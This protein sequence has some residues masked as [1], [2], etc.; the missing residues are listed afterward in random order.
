MADLHFVLSCSQSS[1]S[2][3]PHTDRAPRRTLT[4]SYFCSQPSQSLCPH[5]DRAP[6]RILTSSDL[7]PNPDDHCARTRIAPFGG[8]S[9]RPIVPPTLTIPCAHA[10]RAPQGRSVGGVSQT[11]LLPGSLPDVC[12]HA[13]RAP[14]QILTSSNVEPDPTIPVAA[15]GSCPSADLDIVPNPRDPCARARIV[16]PRLVFTSSDL[17]PNPHDPC[18]RARIVPAG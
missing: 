6:R 17:A 13:D 10:G 2:L 3:C 5:A 8:L 4:S 11:R 9:H 7:T 14:R 18:A 15:R 12:P 16:P 1:R